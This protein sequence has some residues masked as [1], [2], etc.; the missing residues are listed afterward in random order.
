MSFLCFKPSSAVQWSLNKLQTQPGLTSSGPCL[1]LSLLM[2]HPD[3]CCFMPPQ[4][5][6]LSA[7][8]YVNHIPTSGPLYLLFVPS[9]WNVLALNPYDCQFFIQFSAHISSTWSPLHPNC[10]LL[11][12]FIEFLAFVTI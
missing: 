10:F 9:V 4:L 7:P 11:F 1:H 5:T 8:Q 2:P 6:G 12:C 3:L